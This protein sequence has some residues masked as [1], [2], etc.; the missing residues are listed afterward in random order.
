MFVRSLRYYLNVF[1]GVLDQISIFDAIFSLFGTSLLD[2]LFQTI[3][4]SSRWLSLMERGFGRDK[5]IIRN[6]SKRRSTITHY[7][8]L[9]FWRLVNNNIWRTHS[10]HWNQRRCNIS[11]WF[12]I[13][14]AS[15][16]L[17]ITLNLGFFNQLRFFLIFI[18]DFISELLE[19]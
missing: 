10:L 15:I 8:F 6:W 14:W 1:C 4:T 18:F 12:I 3:L 7:K 9:F 13:L 11:T 5:L 19:I 16:T 2:H 17:M